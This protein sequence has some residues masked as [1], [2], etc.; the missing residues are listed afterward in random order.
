MVQ[1]EPTNLKINSKYR[2]M[3]ILPAK[4]LKLEISQET[5]GQVYWP[6]DNQ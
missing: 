2:E 1:G 4:L 6:K 5:N 3:S